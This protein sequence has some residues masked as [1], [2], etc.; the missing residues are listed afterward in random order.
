MR[1]GRFYNAGDYLGGSFC[2]YLE[3][4]GAYS[5]E[6]SRVTYRI[7]GRILYG[8][9]IRPRSIPMRDLNLKSGTVAVSG[10]VFAFEIE[11]KNFSNPVVHTVPLDK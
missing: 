11:S 5:T 3:Q 6:D 9:A 2:D 4:Y 1:R 7:G 8:N 10:K